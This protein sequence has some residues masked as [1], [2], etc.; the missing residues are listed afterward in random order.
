MSGLYHSRGLDRG[1]RCHWLAFITCNTPAHTPPSPPPPRPF[2]LTPSP[3]HAPD[4]SPSLLV[5]ATFAASRSPRRPPSSISTRLYVCL[6]L[7]CPVQTSTFHTSANTLPFSVCHEASAVR[8]PSALLGRQQGSSEAHATATE[9][10]DDVS[11]PAA[12][13]RASAR[14]GAGRVQPPVP[15]ARHSACVKRGRGRPPKRPRL[16]QPPAA[17]RA[18][19][20]SRK[21]ALLDR[22]GRPWATTAY[23]ERRNPVD[24][25]G[26]S[27]KTADNYAPIGDWI[28]DDHLGTHCGDRRCVPE[29]VVRARG[30]G[31]GVEGSKCKNSLVDDVVPPK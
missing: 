26:V 5:P 14:H 18:E 13:A 6:R 20:A 19:A 31:R 29:A 23:L 30:R 17:E 9:A 28:R 21:W 27:V 1:G 8:R 16:P 15:P 12:A 2:P 24:S 10:A 7:H 4:S 3:L 11:G 25:R 22:S